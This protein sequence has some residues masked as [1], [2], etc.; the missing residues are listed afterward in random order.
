MTHNLRLF[1]ILMFLLG[2]F[3][4]AAQENYEVRKVKFKGNKTL[5]KDF[6]I[7]RMALKEVSWVEKVLTKKEPYLYHKEMIDMDMERLIRIY[8]TEGFLEARAQLLPLKIND[9]KKKV[10][11]TIE[12]D[13]GEPVKVDSVYF[14]LSDT[15]KSRVNMDSLTR[16]VFKRVAFTKG[17]RFRDVDLQSD[18][19]AIGNAFRNLGYAYVD[20]SYDL[21]LRPDEYKTDIIYFIHPGPVCYIGNTHIT[22]AK[23]VKDSFIR[24]QLKYEKGD[25]YDRSALEKTRINL[26]HL[27]LFRIVSVLPQP[28][29]DSTRNPIPVKIYIE[30]SPRLNGK[31]G[32]GYGTEDKFRTFLDLNYLGFLGGARRINLQLKHSAIV[33]YSASLRWIQPR[34]IGDRSTIEINPYIERNKE[35]GY[36]NRTIGLRVP[37]NYQFNKWLTSTLTYYFE[38]VEQSVEAD[39]PEF[40]GISG[41][42]FPYNKS[43]VILGSVYDNSKPRFSATSGINLS[44][45]FKLNGYLFGGDF[46][47]TRLWG[48]FRAYHQIGD[49]TLAYKLA[50]GG[51]HSSD[52]SGFIPVEDRFYAGGSISVRGWRRAKLGPKRESG[53]PL[54]GKSLLETSFEVRFPLFWRISAV[55]FV[56]AGNVWTGSYSYR[57]NDLSYAVGPGLRVETP[58]GPVRFDV[59]FPVWNEKKSPQF[60]ISVGQAF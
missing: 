22:G 4:L 20:V 2:S 39:D 45:A 34:F 42:K 56:D 41:D 54:G 12:V 18:K 37:M 59:G 9:K 38:G 3:N 10:K 40:E 47:Y 23:H 51:I 46:S 27:Q 32:L 17:K 16:K 24:K 33:P 48:T 30:E 58:I 28:N 36:D 52:T 55:A 50:A 60:F 44:L 21:N 19:Q 15:V 25:V 53:S 5:D 31:L 49:F 35:P 11:L 57:L 26:Y 1:I 7:E 29:A 14:K 13:E 6:L 43:G 8:Q